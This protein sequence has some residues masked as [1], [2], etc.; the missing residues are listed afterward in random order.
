VAFSDPS[1][2]ITLSGTLTTPA[3]TASHPAVVLVHGSGPLDRDETFFE[4]KPFRVWARHLARHG[5]ASLRF[6][7]RGVGGSG[8]DFATATVD[9]LA[10]DA[11]AAVACLKGVETVD[12]G[13]VGLVGH[14]EGGIVALTSASRSGE[15]AFCVTLA[16]PVLPGPE[17]AALLLALLAEG[18]FERGE[19]F[20]RHIAQLRTLLDL[21]RGDPDPARH[22]TAVQIAT[23][24]ADLIVT[25]R[26]SAMFGGRSRL[27]GEELVELLSSGCLESCLGWDPE[28]VVPQVGCP[29]LALFGERDM[30]VPARENVGAA[31][32][33]FPAARTDDVTVREIPGANHL[34]Q[35]CRTGMPEEYASLDH[36]VSDD[37]LE[38]V[39]S[40]ILSRTER[41]DPAPLS[42]RTRR[43]PR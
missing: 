13:H 31:Q 11:L 38:L 30:Q 12:R 20:E 18:G 22:Q 34:F 2:G 16:G 25:P 33:V 1:S 19:A 41:A 32:R 8:G 10:G 37:V 39:A 42:S 15:L 24:L 23:P 40:W 17:N 43:T 26:T 27:S 6:D 5:I 21:L 36:T 28:S 29:V 7:K 9:D 35:R 3:T 4:L 14:S